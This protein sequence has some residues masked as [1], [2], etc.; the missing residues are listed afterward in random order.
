MYSHPFM[1][2][3]FIR[4]ITDM[5]KFGSS[6][7]QSECEAMTRYAYILPQNLPSFSPQ[8][9]NLALPIPMLVNF[10]P[11]PQIFSITHLLVVIIDI[12]ELT[13]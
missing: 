11:D 2:T 3:L 12:G 6:A 8:L 1:K 9:Y 4:D 7:L 5:A 10:S 13:G